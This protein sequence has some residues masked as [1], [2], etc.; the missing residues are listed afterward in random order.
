[1]SKA[2]KLHWDTEAEKW[3]EIIDSPASPHYLYYR[4]ANLHILS[5]LKD[6]KLVL[7]AGCGTG[8]CTLR[9]MNSELE[10]VAFD[11][12]RVMI[13]AARKKLR[14][15]KLKNAHLVLAAATH[16]PFRD[17]IFEAVFSRGALV[18]YVEDPKR[19]LLE[20]VRVT[21]HRGW[22]GFD[23][24]SGR[25]GGVA[26]GMPLSEVEALLSSTGL[27]GHTLAPMGFLLK[28]GKDPQTFSFLKSNI[29]TFAQIE[30]LLAP[31]VKLE[32]SVMTMV[33]A[34]VPS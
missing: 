24:I 12:S 20:C 13:D 27:G 3:D 16:L 30:L 4:T 28:L 15:A 26:K 6:R 32:C 18:N 31:C 17:R 8:D 22:I 19:F 25:P 5:L 34:Q 11:F 10:L 7:E 9:V 1:L 14:S 33:S 29:D 23:F 2:D 21:Q